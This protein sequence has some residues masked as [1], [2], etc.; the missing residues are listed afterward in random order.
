[1][2]LSPEESINKQG[3]VKVLVADG[4]WLFA[5]NTV[6]LLSSDPR[7]VSVG[8][9]KNGRECLD[10]IHQSRPDVILL[11]IRF[12]DI[13]GIKLIDQIKIA[14]PEIKIIM[15][16]ELDQD[17]YV[18][19]SVKKAA[20]GLLYKDCSIREMIQA[21]LKV[22]EGSNYYSPSSSIFPNMKIDFDDLHIPAKPVEI[23]KKILNPEEKE[24]MGLLIKGLQN[25]EIASALGLSV[26]TV[27]EKV[28]IILLKFGVNT[29]LE[30]VLSW[31]HIKD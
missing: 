13:N 9:A 20:E 28:N 19:A 4:H 1:M 31:A 14:R 27:N 24:I 2:T 3:Q 6:T 18:A 16:A 25:K 21:I 8:I 30:A 12:P 10:M 23:L 22:A 17:G 26:R 29:R 11:D 5:K 7:I 15:M